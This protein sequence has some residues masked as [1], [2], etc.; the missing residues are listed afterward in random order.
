MCYQERRALRLAVDLAICTQLV[1]T[2]Y[3]QRGC[4]FLLKQVPRA[5]PVRLMMPKRVHLRQL[6]LRQVVINGRGVGRRPQML[7]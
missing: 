6:L 7:R 1:L 5:I 2:R 4:T 3:M